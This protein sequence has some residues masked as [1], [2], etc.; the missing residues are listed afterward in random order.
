MLSSCKIH[1]NNTL[2]RTKKASNTI[3]DNN[4]HGGPDVKRP[5]TTSNDFTRP[6][7]TPNENGKKLKTKNNL[8]VG[9]IHNVES[10]DQYLDEV[11]QNNI[12]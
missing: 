12:I 10:N 3:L 9:F 8:K 11:L 1:P 6:Q 2:K 7:S 5:Q 4:T